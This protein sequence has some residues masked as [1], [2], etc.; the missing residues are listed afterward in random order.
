VSRQVSATRAR[1]AVVALYERRSFTFWLVAIALLGLAIRIANIVFVAPWPPEKF[2]DQ[3]YYSTVANALAQGHGF[4]RPAEL[5]TGAPLVPTAERAPLYPLVLAVPCL[6]GI[7]DGDAHRFVSALAGTGTIVVLGLLARRLAGPL[8]GVL[9]A[10]LAAIYPT[11]IAAD[12]ALMTEAL[13]GLLASSSMLAAYRLAEAPSRGRAL[14]LGGLLGLAA[15]TRGEGLLFLPLLLVPVV[16]RPRGPA[17]AGITV[18]AFAVVIAPWTI[19]NWTL[20]D[21]PVLVATEAGE[22]LA[23]AN[24]ADVYS[25][26]KIG[27]WEVRCVRVELSGPISAMNE[28]E[29]FN[30]AGHRGVNYARDHLSR[31][32]AVVVARLR[33]T[34]S[35]FMGVPQVEGRGGRVTRVGIWMY[36]ALVPLALWGLVLLVRRRVAVWILLTP[37][38]TVTVTTV[39]LYGNLRFRQ[40]AELSLVILAA[41]ALSATIQ[42]RWR[43]SPPQERAPTVAVSAR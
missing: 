4:V 26:P 13:F 29:E 39:M 27:G 22:T 42:A 41:V 31:L 19:R 30:T 3:L 20:F 8:A 33:R 43:S 7:T 1:S 14:L 17:M 36:A 15:L 21:R 37:F 25:G 28:A 11:L 32:P 34:W 40:S 12:G 35:V 5:F 23:G 9:A 18:L 24:C 10:G 16:R 38:I 6:M 2:D